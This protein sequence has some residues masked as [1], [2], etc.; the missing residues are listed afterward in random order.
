[1]DEEERRKR[2]MKRIKA[3]DPAAMVQMGTMR[4]EEG[5]YV[6]AVKYWTKAAELGDAAAHYQLSAMYRIGLGIEGDE[7]KAVYHLEKAAICGHATARH[8]LACVEEANG[9]IERAVKHFIINANLGHEGS[10]KKLWPL[11]SA[12]N[13]TKEEL[14]ATLLTHK[15]AL[16]EIKSPEREE[17]EAVYY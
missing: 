6:S 12:G 10:M 7:E 13:I 4:Y 15:A 2:M 5:D 3:N 1:V 9:N 11:Y 8:N 14:E 17:A 16:D